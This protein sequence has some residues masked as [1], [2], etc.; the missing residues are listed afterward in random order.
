M[1]RACQRTTHLR[2]ILCDYVNVLVCGEAAP[3]LNKAML[4]APLQI[5][6]SNLMRREGDGE[7]EEGGERYG[8]SLPSVQ[9]KAT[10]TSDLLH[11]APPAP[12]S[13]SPPEWARVQ[14]LALLMHPG[15]IM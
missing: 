5:I 10:C 13:P 2:A 11:A 9:C 14:G 1:V 3:V 6:S 8:Q 7:G 15:S 12:L 4:P